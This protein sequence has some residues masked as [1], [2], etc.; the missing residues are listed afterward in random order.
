MSE[1]EGEEWG[2]LRQ[3]LEGEKAASTAQLLFKSARLLQTYALE[4]IRTEIGVRGIRPSHTALFPHIDVKGTRLTEI[5][6]RA[7]ISKQAVGVLVQEMEEMGSS[8]R[9]ST[10]RMVGRVS[11]SSR[12]EGRG[13][14]KAYAPS[15]ASR[16]TSFATSA[17]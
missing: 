6:K 9:S 15:D 2:M 11:S 7:E 14:S 16:P 8:R 3:K 17:F 10:R 1:R 13:S 4:R 5:A 12:E